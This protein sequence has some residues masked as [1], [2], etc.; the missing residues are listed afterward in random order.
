MIQ[1]LVDPLPRLNR[2]ERFPGCDRGELPGSIRGGS[3][4]LVEL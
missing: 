2:K 3:H 4:V 1:R